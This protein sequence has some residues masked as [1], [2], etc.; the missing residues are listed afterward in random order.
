[1]T[2]LL[3]FRENAFDCVTGLICLIKSRLHSGDAHCGCTDGT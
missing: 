3:I 1:M 2:G